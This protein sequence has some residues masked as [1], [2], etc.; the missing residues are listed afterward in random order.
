[1]TMARDETA[2]HI[3]PLQGSIV[4]RYK[5]HAA[6]AAGE[7]VMKNGDNDEVTPAIGTAVILAPAGVAINAGAAAGDYIDVVIFGP[8]V[9]VTGATAGTLCYATDTAG[10]PGVAADT[11][12]KDTVFGY[13][14]NA[15][16]LF[17]RPQIVD[18]S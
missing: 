2:E 13:F 15:T 8:V 14:E 4:R 10:E 16:T 11:H 1:M 9:C 12:T 7:L 18:F 17:V 5:C 3:K 6:V